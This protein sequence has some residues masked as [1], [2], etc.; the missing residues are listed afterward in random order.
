MAGEAV[1]RGLK[2]RFILGVVLGVTCAVAST[3]VGAAH[4]TLLASPS[5]EV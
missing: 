5:V 1:R 4:T 2:V 3:A